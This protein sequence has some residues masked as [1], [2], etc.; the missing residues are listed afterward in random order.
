MQAAQ[1]ADRLTVLCRCR[2]TDPAAADAA[3]CFRARRSG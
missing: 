1:V 3:L 2:V